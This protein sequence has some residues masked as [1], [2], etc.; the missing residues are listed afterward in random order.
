[1]FK[2]LKKDNRIYHIASMA[3]SGET[4]I[5]KILAIHPDIK[6]VHN[7]DK[8][9]DIVQS[10]AFEFLKSY[11]KE[12]ISRSHPVIKPYNLNKHQV[13]LLKQGV[14]KHP[15]PFKGLILS[16]NP[17]SIY[18]SLKVYDKELQEY[19][20]EDN[21]WFGVEERL[22]RWLK[23]ID[24]ESIPLIK[25]M[26]PVE[27]FCLFYNIRMK[28]LLM[29]NLPVIR[30]ED[31]I[32]DTQLT[33]IKICKIIGVKMDEKLL[34]AHEF[35][36]EGKTGHGKI[37]LSRK[38]DKTSLNKYKEIVTDEEF[39]LIMNKTKDVYSKFGYELKNNEVFYF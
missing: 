11:R 26:S 7:L 13:L 10:L 5:L 4:L 21:F 28:G 8:N 23:N 33:L 17:I 35:Y 31:L 20:E 34:V 27:Q 22:L 3:R 14:W 6:V 39:E 38:I 36:E 2:L 32:L 18:A 9:D 30:Y 1:M 12:I 37:D 25:N 19:H 29:T 16:R 24:E 15:Y